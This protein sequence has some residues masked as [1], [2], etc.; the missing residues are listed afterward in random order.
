VQQEEALLLEI[1][2]RFDASRKHAPPCCNA[3]GAVKQ[4]LAM[5]QGLIS[6]HLS[7]LH[8]IKIIG[9]TKF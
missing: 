1:I 4:S 8:I 2:T 6:C 5:L 7:K 9:V 3:R